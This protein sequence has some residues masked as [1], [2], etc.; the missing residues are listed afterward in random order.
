MQKV[1]VDFI[2][3]LNID[4]RY[5]IL[6]CKIVL[7]DNT[8]LDINN[9]K[10]WSDSFKIEDAVSNP[11]KFDIGAVV[12]NKLT[13]T[14]NNIYDEYT[15]YDFT[16][17]VVKNVRVGLELP[18]GTEEYVKKGMYTVD[19][20]SYNGSLITL[21]CLDN[22]SKFDVSYKESKLVYPATIGAIVRDA[23]TECGVGLNTFEF[24][25]HTYIVQERPSDEALTFRQVLNW[26]AQIACCFARCNTEGKLELKWFQTGILEDELDGGVYDNGT[27]KYQTGDDSDGGVYA[28]W[29][30]G[31]THSG[32]TF[33]DLLSAHHFIS[34]A[35][36]EISTDD[37][38]ITGILVKEYSPDIDKDEIV[39]YLTGAEGYVLSIEENRFIP[40]GRG[41]EVAAYLGSRLIGLRFRPLS[42]SC[43]SDPTVEAGDVGFFTDRKCKTYKFL[44]T[45]TVFS[46]GNYQTVTCDAQ[47]PARNKATR[48]SAATQAYVELR[49]Q[50]RKERTEREKALEELGNRLAA[51][52]GLYTT[53]EVQASG[54]K[55]FYLHD[56]P[57]LAD[58][59]IVWKMNAEAWG[60]S[61]DGGKSWNGGMT[62][63]GDTI[64]RI[65]TAIGVSASWIDT[66][67]ISVKD[68]DENIIFLVDMDTKE[69]VISGDSVRIGG[70]SVTKAIEEVN[71]AANK[72]LQEAEKMRTLNIQLENDAHVVPTDADGNNG[73]YTGCDTTVYVLWGQTDISAD[74][75]ITVSKSAGVVGSWNT[76]TRKY[77]VTN[78][79]TDAGYVDF[80]VK[81]MEIT[82][83][84]RFSISKNKQGRQ[85]EH[86]L[87]GIPGKDGGDGA[88]GR[89]SYFHVMYAPVVNPTAAQMSKEPDA[90]I[91]TYVDFSELDSRDP[92]VYNWVKI[93]GVDGKDGT[94]GIPGKNGIDGKTSYLHIKYSDDGKTFSANNGETP[95]AWVGTYV[96]FIEADSSVF[97]TYAWKKIEGDKGK[98]G[99]AG[100]TYFIDASTVII[101]RG[102]DGRIS[103]TSVTFSA[104]YRDGD[105]SKRTP[106]YGR[107]IVSESIDGEAWEAKYTSEIDEISK[108]Y[109]P[110]EF[111]T[112]VKCVLYAAGGTQ[113]EMDQ[114]TVSIVVD[115]SNLT[116]EIIFDTLTNNGEDQGVYL[117]DGK[118]YINM[119]YTK[120]G[121]LVL[122]G[123]DDTNGLLR[124]KDKSD[125]EIGRWGSDGVVIEKGSFTTT[126]ES[127]TASIGG[128]RVHVSWMGTEVGGIGANR[129][130]SGDQQ[131]GL[132]FDLESESAYMAWSA[133]NKSTDTSYSVKFIYAH[134]NFSGYEAGN[135]YLGANLNTRGNDILL[136]TGGILKSWN[137]VSGFKTDNFSVV[138][139]TSNTTFLSAKPSGIDFYT[140]L[141]MNRYSVFNQS[142][143]RL[144][145]NITE[146]SVSALEAVKSIEVKSFDWLTD[147]K[148]V[149]AGIIAQQLQ[150]IIPGLVR[151]DEKGLLSI[152][153]VGLIP[154][155]V[156]AI[157]ELY[158]GIMPVNLMSLEEDVTTYEYTAEEKIAAVELAK[159]PVLED[160]KPEEIIIKENV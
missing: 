35:S 15:E 142:D 107:F 58:S 156:K 157:Q 5:Y 38:V 52:S 131:S 18:D 152:N 32:G 139:S 123:L 154:Y 55:I 99:D 72:A 120:G 90:F 73:K 113:T 110:T 105:N 101:K 60:V 138:P 160:V 45:N 51:S 74:V 129:F 85:G 7:S 16:D 9:T 69:I 151:E 79:T 12:A 136:R 49:K 44:V 86:G 100:R 116:Q 10:L 114:Q 1:S 13:L 70:K 68:K 108:G 117:K 103:P 66:G 65:L 61:T 78:M 56:R 93:E 81:Y 27:P 96:D 150:Q 133:R 50:I 71:N 63:D 31:D 22:M 140:D 118:I 77:T 158:T 46:S 43:L 146:L 106:Y 155:L 153:Y 128:G 67:R 53:V 87:Q 125:Q 14:L 11:G 25:N 135:L 124:V 148:H 41:Q 4:N 54:G 29:N 111:A 89:T 33:K 115:V 28:P 88:D 149:D 112:A 2:K 144:K 26:C 95:G 40:P 137:N 23:C 134:K 145:E 121:T 17:A 24:T 91:G 130:E 57:N 34:Y 62:V 36:P 3:E 39:P 104:Y 42:F 8:E 147:G 76:N 109:V 6:D 132:V 102:Q 97:S 83:T 47:T 30:E 37:V 122:G 126:T 159:P 64:V 84:K 21:E 80:T 92:M 141:D 75:P 98:P 59:N 82:A 119:T 19:D 143:A 127:S 20:T 94:N 48:Y